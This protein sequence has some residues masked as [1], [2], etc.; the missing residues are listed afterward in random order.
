MPGVAEEL[1]IVVVGD[2]DGDSVLRQG[3]AALTSQ[4]VT[5]RHAAPLHPG[6]VTLPNLI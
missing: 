4:A 1:Q 3:V 6:L 2:E 5:P